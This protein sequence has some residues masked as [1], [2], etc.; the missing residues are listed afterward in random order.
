MRIAFAT[1]GA[2]GGT[3]V[4]EL[5]PPHLSHLQAEW[6]LAS[7]ARPLVREGLAESRLV[8]RFDP[9][10][11]G[12]S[13]R[14]AVDQTLEGRLADLEAV[15]DRLALKRF[16]LTAHLGAGMVAIAYAARHPER[17]SHLVLFDAYARGAVRWDA[18]RWRGLFA[19]AEADWE[20]FTE[21]LPALVSGWSGGEE[22]RAFA[23]Y[24]RECMT[25]EEIGRASC[26][27]RVY[28]LV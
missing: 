27:E 10:G 12:L 7:R 19:L 20:V 23:A 18:P 4:V 17:V 5:R 26:R 15:V 28:V 9:R 24:L 1:F 2:G 16:A 14:G 25:R 21:T 8:V 3:P 6:R 22:T 13:D 11:S